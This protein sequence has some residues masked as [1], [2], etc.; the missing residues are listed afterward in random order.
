MTDLKLGELK[1]KAEDFDG[2][3][4]SSKAITY[5]DVCA[6][7]NERLA[8]KLAKAPV[9]YHDNRLYGNAEGHEGH[10]V[11]CQIRECYTGKTSPRHTARLV[12]I[13]KVKK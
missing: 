12:C 5:Q 13:E 4:H 2:C 7:V 1:F 3:W 8:E 9:V 6:R 11:W 10:S